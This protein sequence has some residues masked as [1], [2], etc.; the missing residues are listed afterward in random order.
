MGSFAHRQ[1]QQTPRMRASVACD[2]CRRSKIK[3]E[4]DGLNTLCKQCR[5][6][7]RNCTYSAQPPW[8]RGAH[9]LPLDPEASRK[10]QKRIQAPAPPSP[11]L[12][13]S[14]SRSVE[15]LHLDTNVLT[16]KVWKELWALFQQH[17]AADFPF[18]HEPTFLN[19]A[20][21]QPNYAPSVLLAFLTLTAPLCPDL[22]DQI[23][24]QEKQPKAD[25]GG[26]AINRRKTTSEH[27]YKAAKDSLGY[28]V[29]YPVDLN[30]GLELIQ[31]LLMLGLYEIVQCKGRKAWMTIG[32][33]IDHARQFSLHKEQAYELYRRESGLS[34]REDQNIQDEKCR[35]TFWSCFIMDVHASGG[36][37]RKRKVDPDEIDIQMPCTERAFKSGRAV[38]AS[39]LVLKDHGSQQD[40]GRRHH[41]IIL[42]RNG[43]ERTCRDDGIL[44]HYIK[45]L[46]LFGDTL[47]WSVDGGRRV[48]KY[49]PW[50]PKSY[51]DRFQKRLDHLVEDLPEDFQSSPH[52]LD[53]CMRTADYAPY[54]LTHELH[55]LISI[56]LHREYIPFVAINCKGPRGPLDEPK[57]PEEKYG[58]RNAFWKGSAE[59]CF[60]AAQKL[61]DLLVDCEDR[62]ALVE[63]PMTLYAAFQVTV[64][65]VYILH[66]PGMDPRLEY[67]RA[68]AFKGFSILE[69]RKS[70][71]LAMVSTH[72]RN[73]KRL[74]DYYNKAIEDHH[75]SKQRWESASEQSGSSADSKSLK[76][77]EGGPG[78]GLEDYKAMFESKLKEI[79]DTRTNEP[80]EFGDFEMAPLKSRFH[81]EKQSVHHAAEARPESRSSAFT[82][83]NGNFGSPNVTL[84]TL[85]S[86]KIHATTTMASPKFP[87]PPAIYPATYVDMWNQY[88][89]VH[90]VIG[91]PQPQR[92]NELYSHIGP[93]DQ[94]GGMEFP[95]SDINNTGYDQSPYP[96][97]YPQQ[98]H[99]L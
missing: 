35:R 63:T 79:V 13:R 23:A 53:A 20:S 89:T 54:I 83:V 86:P 51:L 68:V 77:V 57:F 52:N 65:G 40:S 66:F 64:C 15:N 4:N 92:S 37:D 99:S 43:Q 49:P 84:A 74:D 62:G 96:G 82:P 32:I 58:N 28:I 78:G 42:T 95:F 16:P 47:K 46:L 90:P 91:F 22:V 11:S 2:K 94:F 17:F 76:F 1:D 12:A 18:F 48:D 36:R 27:Y 55:S 8:S 30:S 38:K 73:I 9:P 5:D 14:E 80:D 98:Q 81:E 24:P 67:D 75:K 88:Q 71:G 61:T 26:P 56:S 97:P 39:R 21:G 34:S 70:S 25:D 93:Y 33:A 87:H 29:D 50:D 45:A 59:E 41:D 44:C 72:W 6:H 7:S 69:K 85:D 3:C 31:S 60:K 10:R 19:T